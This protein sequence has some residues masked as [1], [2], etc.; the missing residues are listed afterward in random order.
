MIVGQEGLKDLR[1]MV[2]IRRHDAKSFSYKCTYIGISL[3]FLSMPQ[4]RE[5]LP[6]RVS[7]HACT[8]SIR[9][10]GHRTAHTMKSCT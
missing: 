7:C 1:I 8:C 9:Q 4:V 3:V 6:C 2:E 10:A 5:G